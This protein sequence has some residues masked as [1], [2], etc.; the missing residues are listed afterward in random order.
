FTSVPQGSPLIEGVAAAVGVRA[1]DVVRAVAAED[2]ASHRRRAVADED[3]APAIEGVG[4]VPQA[5]A[6]A[7]GQRASVV[8]GAAFVTC[9]VVGKGAIADC[10]RAKVGD[11][12]AVGR[13]I[14]GQRA[15]AHLQVAANIDE[16]GAS[17]A[18]VG[19]SS[20]G[21]RVGVVVT[22]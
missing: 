14:V 11:G 22:Y 7:D 3:A 18:V 15:V 8:D 1:Q 6:P 16:D 20:V 2:A 17:I 21:C 10:Q 5:G 9:D 12:A 4:R 13:R 19:D